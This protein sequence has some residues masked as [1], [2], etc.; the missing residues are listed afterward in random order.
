MAKRTA[1]IDIGSNSVRM[2]VFEKTSRFA[3]H[4]LHE[5]KSRVRISEYAYEND[6]NLQSEAMDRALL[7]LRDFLSISR[8]YGVRK[9]LSVATSAVRDA[10]NK[11]EFL[12]RVSKELG[13]KIKVIDGEKEGYLGGIACAN[14]LPHMDAVTIDIGGGSTECA[15]IENGKVLNSYSLDIGTVRLKE[16]FFDRQDIKG[17]VKYID[18]ALKKLPAKDNEHVIG[19]GGT[20][21][22]LS[23]A[24]MQQSDYPLEKLHGYRFTAK[25]L[26]KFGEAILK[27]DEET[28][29][30]MGIKKERF[31]VIKPGTLILLRV[32]HH[33]QSKELTTSGVGV[34]EGVYLSDL[35][36]HNNHRFPENYNPSMRY[37]LDKYIIEPGQMQRIKQVASTLFDLLHNTFDIPY[38]YKKELSIAAKLSKIGTSLH[39]YS[40]HQHSYYL[41]QTALEYGYT[42]E[43]IMLIST[44]VRYQKRKRPKKVHRQEYE[45][46]LPDEKI[47]EGLS[48]IL[49]LADALLSDHPQSIDFKLYYARQTISVESIAE[50]LYL[51][52]EVVKNLEMPKGISVEF[53]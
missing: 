16:L 4:L 8:S 25:T 44:L 13:L 47:I 23:R 18:K 29:K 26:I 50:T 36:R 22:A 24:I 21:R 51:P 32:L 6:G 34:R 52:K 15:C 39:Y 31:D 9:T 7:A 10:P 48:F 40:Y 46:L 45:L 35:L 33:L 38:S 19:I 20:F 11:K 28:L 41:T 1:I 5:V 17:A 27:A 12:K 53:I 49:A 3:F 42:H 43:Q 2:V 14:L 37:L 30:Q